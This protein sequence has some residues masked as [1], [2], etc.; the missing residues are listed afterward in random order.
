MLLVMQADWLYG[1]LSIVAEVLEGTLA[2]SVHVNDERLVVF[3]F[4]KKTSGL[5]G[6]ESEK[7]NAESSQQNFST[8]ND[9]KWHQLSFIFR[10]ED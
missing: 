1:K 9:N 7:K 5:H 6:E 8:L 2:A 4:N 10:S 3:A